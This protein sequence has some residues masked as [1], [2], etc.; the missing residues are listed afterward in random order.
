MLTELRKNVAEMLSQCPVRRPC[1]VRRSLT[2]D[3]LLAIDLPQAA[4]TASVEKFL[5]LAQ[6]N[7]WKA[8]IEKGWILLDHALPLPPSHAEAEANGR[9]ANTLQLLRLHPS[10]AMDEAALRALAKAV[11]E[12]QRSVERLCNALAQEWA[13]RL[14][15]HEM[16]PGALLPYLQYAAYLLEK[17]SN[18]S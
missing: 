1:A 6:Q 2:A 5:R 11:E 9:L 17:R 12:G 13:V 7:G 8:R 4:E 14:R 15:Q 18:A 10:D 16:L 3:A